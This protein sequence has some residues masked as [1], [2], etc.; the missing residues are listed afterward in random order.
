MRYQKIVCVIS[1]L[2]GAAIFFVQC[3]GKSLSPDPRGSVY[4]GSESC[5]SCHKAIVE[6]YQHN[7]H[8]QTSGK[9]SFDELKKFINASNN[10]FYYAD[11]DRVK[12]EE[13]HSRFFQSHIVDGKIIRSEE[14]DI[15]I[16]SA[17]KAQT[18]A[19]WKDEQLFQLPLT[20]FTE[21]KIWTNSP[22]Y[23]ASKPYFD[24]VILSRCLEC[25]ASYVQKTDIQT[26]PLQV[27]EKF[28]PQS[29]VFGIDCERCH[30]PAARHV[31]FHLEHKEEK[32]SKYIRSIHTLTQQQQLDWCA[33]CHSGND[34]DVLRPI[35]SF[36]PGDT[37]AN[38]YYPHFGSGKPNPD[39][40]GKQLQLLQS[41][42]CFQNS[43]MSC[44]TCHDTHQPEASKTELFITKCMNCHQSEHALQMKTATQ[45]CIDC[46]MPLQASKSLDFNNGTERQRIPYLLR[47]HRIAVYPKLE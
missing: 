5:V 29:I 2:A 16:G 21:R 3:V 43:T 37:L 15:A 36:Q 17:E 23:P 10:L 30:G 20:Y 19:Y 45:N 25:H 24:R 11:S 47:T 6:S 28:V 18:Y 44:Q 1:L 38:F 46:H 7:P 13:K 42:K 22:G 40:H 4:A 41:S 39:V 32:K 8:Y 31:Q 12:L 9:V 14:L 26:G 34:I 35:F 33:S 27:T